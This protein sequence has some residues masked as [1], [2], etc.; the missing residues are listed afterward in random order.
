[1]SREI[2]SL[3]NRLQEAEQ[4]EKKAEQ[5]R[6]ALKEEVQQ[7][8]R[9][10]PPVNEVPLAILKECNVLEATMRQVYGEIFTI[11]QTV[12]LLVRARVETKKKHEQ[13]KEASTMLDRMMDWTTW[14]PQA[15]KHV[16]KKD[17]IHTQDVKVQI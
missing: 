7:L 10:T 6:T 5:E 14:Y 15:P 3:Q 11:K 4:R 13:L 12:A 8:R 9:K 1:M 17:W 2:V 16:P